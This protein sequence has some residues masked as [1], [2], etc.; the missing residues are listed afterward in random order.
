MR[1]ALVLLVLLGAIGC[2]TTASLEISSSE[3][4]LAFYEVQWAEECADPK[5][6]FLVG[7]DPTA[8]PKDE[9]CAGRRSRLNAW[10]THLYQARAALT[11]GGSMDLQLRQLRADQ[12]AVANAR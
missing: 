7:P 11:R 10:R 5:P 9:A 2:S 8:K 1:S 4:A 3:N 6:G 12:K